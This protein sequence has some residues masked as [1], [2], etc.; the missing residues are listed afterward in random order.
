[1]KLGETMKSTIKKYVSIREYSYQIFENHL[2]PYIKSLLPS[3]V[4]YKD[5]SM[6]FQLQNTTEKK[7]IRPSDLSVKTDQKMNTLS[8]RLSRLE[9]GELI[10]RI[11]NP[12][13]HRE[14]MVQIT[15]KGLDLLGIYQTFYHRFSKDLNAR[16]KKSELLSLIRVYIRVSNAFTD[17]PPIRF[18]PLKLKKI[19]EWTQ[20]AISRF[21][22]KTVSLE[23]DL[24]EKHQIPCTLREWAVF[25]EIYIQSSLEGCMLSTLKDALPYPISTLS[26]IIKRYDSTIVQKMVDPKDHRITHVSIH[27]TY[28]S[29]FNAYIDLRIDIQK[30]IESLVSKKEYVLMIKAFESIETITQ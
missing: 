4:T 18:N 2:L 28:H 7:M 9:K 27:P 12:E 17:E 23:L 11:P 25:T 21:Y 26:T 14:I 8:Y 30:R 20:T 15:P 13:D 3:K 19:P 10:V 1:M 22:N 5:L 24:L 6:L 29:T 16:L